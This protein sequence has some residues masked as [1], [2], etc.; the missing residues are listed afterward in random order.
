MYRLRYPD[1]KKD[2]ERRW[3]LPERVFFACGACHIL[4][5]AFL[6]TYP[7]SDFTPMWIRPTGGLPGNHIVVVRDGWAFDYHGYS[8]WHHLLS[9]FEKKA[10]RAWPTWD[11]HLIELPQDVLISEAKSRTYDGLWLR[12]PKQ[13][14]YDALPRA[15]NYLHRFASPGEVLQR[16]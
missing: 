14:L 7:A 4:A 13:F 3:A 2:P 9:H 10:R 16:A 6:E 15:H 5:F 12:G 1:T 8:E 11:A